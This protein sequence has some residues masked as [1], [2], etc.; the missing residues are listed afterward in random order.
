MWIR[1]WRS[2]F[3]RVVSARK[4]TTRKVMKVE[5]T[6]S[7]VAGYLGVSASDHHRMFSEDPSYPAVTISRQVGAGSSAVG[8]LL[9]R[10]FQRKLD[11]NAPPWTLYGSELIQQ[12][13][14]KS[15]LP[16]TLARYF[17]EAR[18]HSW[19]DTLEELMGLHPSSYEI[20]RRCHEM[21]VNLCRLGNAVIVGR[22]GNV[23]AKGLPNVL[24]VRLV[25]SLERRI[26]R[27]IA[28]K[29][30]SDAAARLY[31]KKEDLERERYAKENFSIAN[32]DDPTLYDL[33]VNTDTFSPESVAEMIEDAAYAK[34][35]RTFA[36]A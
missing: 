35:S 4:P 27:I 8:E 22:C 17:P 21:I 32:L 36:H 11:D 16:E 14:R 13:L 31:A 3:A 29:G 2:G 5:T 24:H 26:E 12:V 6:L 33:V 10:R 15:D 28:G 25:G 23:L 9:V 19:T 20:N 30:I 34:F 1:F 18:G 7:A